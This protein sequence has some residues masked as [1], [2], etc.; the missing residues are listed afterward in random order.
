MCAQLSDI[1]AVFMIHIIS[2]F[3]LFGLGIVC[4]WIN[5]A[6]SFIT[7][8]QLSSLFMCWLRVVLAFIT[9]ALFIVHYVL[10]Q[11][12]YFHRVIKIPVLII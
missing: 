5:V 7:Q 8:P 2:A 12:T 4:A 9:T 6:L 10:S 3:V 11:P 1:P